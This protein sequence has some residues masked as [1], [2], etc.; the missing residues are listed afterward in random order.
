M[1]K[2]KDYWK[3]IVVVLCLGWV[4]IWIYRTWLTPIY[5]DI[6]ATIGEQGNSAM[7]LIASF[8]FFGYTGMQIPSGFLVDK[9]GRKA[10]IIPGFLLFAL[11]AVFIGNATSINMIYAG[12]LMAGVGTGAYYGSAYSLTATYIPDNHRTFATAI[13][14]SGSAVGM[15]IGLIGSSFLI[16]N[17]ELPWQTTMFIIAGIIAAMAATF[18]IFIKPEDEVADVANVIKDSSDSVDSNGN[19][20]SFFSLRLIATYA[21]YFVT[22]Y[23]Y[24]MIVTWLPNFLET[25]RGFTGIAIGMSSALVAFASIP[26]ALFFSRRADKFKDRKVA[27]IFSL[28][29]LAAGMLAIVV[30][31][32]NSTILLTGLIL[33]GFLGKLAVDPILISYIIDRANPSK[34]GRSLGL[35]NFFGMT[36]SVV[37]PFVTGLISDATGSKV[38]GFYVSVAM[39]ILGALFFLYANKL[40]Q[41]KNA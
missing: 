7:G 35:F 29:L 13:I 15:A 36:S 41:K 27:T 34:L 31:S 11:A 28:E 39:L 12:S 20:E 23:G 6:Q 33:Y 21:L 25:E 5:S 24:Y 37:A 17:L 8:Y 40:D 4:S 18:F 10:I 1:D 9:V 3:R 30:L 22:C 26:G 38:L 2:N 19:E 16:K 32:P 14:N